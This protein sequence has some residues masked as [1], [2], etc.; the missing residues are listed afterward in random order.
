MTTTRLLRG[1]REGALWFGALAGLLA[2]AAGVAVVALNA[3]FLVFRSGSMA[4]EI[5]TGALA[6]ARP[7]D[8]PDIRTGDIV[9]VRSSEGAQ[10]THR[11]VSSTVRGDE[12]SLVLQGDANST[13]DGELY[14]VQTVQRVDFSAPYAGYVVAYGMTPPGLVAIAAICLALFLVSSDDVTETRPGPDR[15]TRRRPRSGRAAV[16]ATVVAVTVAG[17]AVTGTQAAF[18]DTATMT[19]GAFS[20]ATVTPPTGVACVNVA[21]NNDYIG[22]TAPSGYTPTAY[23]VYVNGSA[24]PTATVTPP[25][26]QWAPAPTLFGASY[27]VR[28]A[29]VRG[30]WVSTQA[31][32]AGISAV[33]F[34]GLF[35]GNTC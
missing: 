4:P 16:T 15:R 20:T 30:T 3:S 1:A 33:A 22:W 18:N 25:T 31:G 8:A 17:T 34:L 11:V 14:V 32:P 9:T 26:T 28:V 35:S 2:V 7:V 29:A 21:G 19:T 10:I 24:N 23:R 6:F 27:T 5:D 13:P 12:A